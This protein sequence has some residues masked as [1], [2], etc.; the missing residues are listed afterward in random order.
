VSHILDK[1]RGS[2]H[3]YI[4]FNCYKDQAAH[5]DRRAKEDGV[6]V[7]E[8]IRNLI[9]EDIAAE[10]EAATPEDEGAAMS[11]EDEAREHMQRAP[12]H[13]VTVGADDRWHC[14]TCEAGEDVLLAEDYGQA[15]V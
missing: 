1:D 10:L 6:S 2:M 15:G 11:A 12:N 5:L 9:D 13:D 14:L 3:R 4:Q 7:A 8:I